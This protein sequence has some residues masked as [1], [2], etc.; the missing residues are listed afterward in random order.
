MK[1]ERAT[2]E[3]REVAALFALGSLTQQ[4]AR[5]FET[6]IRDGCPVCDA[7]RRKYEYAASAIGFSVEEVAPP[8]YIRDV[9]A[10]RIEREPQAGFA[11]AP[12]DPKAGKGQETEPLRP[13]PRPFLTM[14][15]PRSER[16]NVFLWTLV[17]LLAISVLVAAYAWQTAHEANGRLRA[18]ASALRA[19]A[20]GLTSELDGHKLS[21]ANLEQVLSTVEK[22]G[23]RIARLAV[24]ASPPTS[25]AAVVWDTETESCLI[26]GNFPPAPEGKTYQLWLFAPMGRVPVGSLSV[27]TNGRVFANVPVPKDAANAGMAVVTLEPD[28][29][30]QIPTYPYYASG[31]VQ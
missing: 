19:D 15:Q 12:A 11:Q 29:G 1:H 27:D 30:S 24:Q 10:A 28:N 23:T 14:S 31:R 26:L 17:V 4:E 20:E 2:E 6:H 22:P 7:E 18:E 21:S 25:S 13:S 9:L 16:S 5:S 8:V 3:L